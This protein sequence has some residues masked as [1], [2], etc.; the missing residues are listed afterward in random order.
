MTIKYPCF[1]RAYILVGGDRWKINKT[2]VTWQQDGDTYDIEEKRRPGASDNVVETGW[3]GTA[4][5]GRWHWA[6]LEG[7]EGQAISI[8]KESSKQKK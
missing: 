3:S 8:W 7:G 5:L 4:L 2:S 6:K 1:H